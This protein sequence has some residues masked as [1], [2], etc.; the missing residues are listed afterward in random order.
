MT[1][2]AFAVALNTKT[3]DMHSQKP[4][5]CQ[6]IPFLEIA[7]LMPTCS[8][9]KDFQVGQAWLVRFREFDFRHSQSTLRLPERLVLPASNQKNCCLKR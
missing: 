3:D 1:I 5:A 7:L 9:Q 2:C 6:L 4:L 8:L